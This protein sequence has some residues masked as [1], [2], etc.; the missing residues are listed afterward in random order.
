M[1]RRQI[2]VWD[3]FVRVFHWSLV[4]SFTVAYVTEDE[5]LSLHLVAGYAVA[6]LIGLRLVWGFVGTRYAR[7]SNFVC[8]PAR[9]KAFL[10]DSLRLRAKRYIG[11][12][13]AG[14]AMIL[15]MLAALLLTSITGVAL[16]GIEGSAGPLATL[17]Q[18]W[19]G[20]GESMEGVHEFLAS[21]TLL[22]VGIHIA[23]VLVESL[24]HHENLAKSMLTGMKRT[25]RD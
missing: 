25:A 21:L 12:N 22:M 18:S 1:S 23:G 16:Y 2:K 24:I 15:L 11:H 8:R 9:I 14:G 17:S 19:A 3:I 20:W 13:P 10:K 7:F 5:L 4:A 6:G